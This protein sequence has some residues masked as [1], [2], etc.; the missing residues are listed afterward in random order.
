MIDKHPEWTKERAID[1]AFDVLLDKETISYRDLYKAKEEFETDLNEELD[2][3]DV[4][5]EALA[6][7]LGLTNDDLDYIGSDR[8]ETENQESIYF[9]VTKD[10]ARY[11]AKE[12]IEDL[13]FDGDDGIEMF[14][15]SFQEYIRFECVDG[16]DVEEFIDNEIEYYTSQEPDNEM[17]DYL[18]GLTNKARY[19][20]D[21]LGKEGYDEWLLTGPSKINIDKVANKAIEEDGVAH[22]LATYDSN[23]IDLG[24]GLFAYRVY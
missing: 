5:G 7:Y 24:N 12:V 20:Y 4:R 23:E 18:N 19:V 21:T 16:D 11:Y 13:L 2:E 17:L 3:G 6:S 8:Y 10:E 1:F 14:T 9:V 22:F 15:P